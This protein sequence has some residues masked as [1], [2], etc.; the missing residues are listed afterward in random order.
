MNV[1]HAMVVVITLVQIMM[2]PTFVP[3]TLD[4]LWGP[5]TKHVMVCKQVLLICDMIKDN[6]LILKQC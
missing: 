6:I 2:G 4:I 1:L 5:M 3:A